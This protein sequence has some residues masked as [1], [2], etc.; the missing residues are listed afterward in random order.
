MALH[1]LPPL[2]GGPNFILPR[3]FV[4]GG[5]LICVAPPPPHQVMFL[6]KLSVLHG[7][8]L[9]ASISSKDKMTEWLYKV[10]KLEIRI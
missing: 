3:V 10:D 1:S 5:V 8:R 4:G 9:A 6:S 2:Q 7:T